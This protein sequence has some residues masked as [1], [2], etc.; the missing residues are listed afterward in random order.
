MEVYE[1]KQTYDENDNYIHVIGEIEKNNFD[2]NS[3]L[4]IVSDF[5]AYKVIKIYHVFPDDKFIKNRNY[6]LDGGFFYIHEKYLIK[7]I[8][9]TD[10]KYSMYF[11]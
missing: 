5:P 8:D 9:K 6:D 7:K 4:Y 10:L 11:I 1:I 2:Q 3:K